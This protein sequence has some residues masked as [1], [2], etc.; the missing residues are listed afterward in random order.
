MFEGII[1]FFKKFGKEEKQDTKSKE[2]AKER[3]HLVLMQD[4][5]NVSADFLEMM[6]QEIID[7]IKKYITVDES[8]IDVRLTNKTNEDGTSGAPALYANIPIVS[9][10]NEN[11][12]LV[13]QLKDSDINK[14]KGNE[15]E[16]TG[17]ASKK[18][19]TKKEKLEKESKEIDK[20]SKKIDKK[21]ESKENNDSEDDNKDKINQQE[22]SKEDE[23]KDAK[24][25][26]K[27]KITSK[28][29]TTKK[30]TKKTTAKK[31]A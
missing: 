31:N 19:A 1:S 29:T 21:Q 18:S 25:D 15:K 14:E 23:K 17:K 7:V 11:K 26:N 13:K 20:D 10:K 6:K 3:L 24:D 8:E 9:I 5:A 22:I 4:R 16:K 28:K 27:K 2:K 12:N 30:V